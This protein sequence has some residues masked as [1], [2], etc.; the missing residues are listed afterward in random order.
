MV[1]VAA[2]AKRLQLSRLQQLKLGSAPSG[3][4]VLLWDWRY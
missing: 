2:G 1:V 4:Y 3:R